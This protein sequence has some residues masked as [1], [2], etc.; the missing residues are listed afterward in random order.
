MLRG[1]GLSV[2][3]VLGLI[4][5]AHAEPQVI[6]DP[7]GAPPEV[8]QSITEAVSAITRLAEDQD[9]REVSRLRRRAWDAARAALQTQGYFSPVVTLDVSEGAPGG[10]EFWDI[11]IEPG[12][13]TQVRQLG[14]NFTGAIQGES[15]SSR[16]E[17]LRE[18][19]LLK[20]GMPFINSEWGS[21]KSDLR[22][23]LSR[24][25]FY[26]ARYT[27]TRATVDP[28]AASADLDLE[29]NSGPPVRLGP[30]R[31]EGLKRVPE[32]LIA[33]YVRYSP[34]DP[35][36]QDQLDMWQQALQSTSFFRGA[37]VT[38]GTADTDNGTGANGDSR[39]GNGNNRNGTRAGVDMSSVEPVEL[40]VH[41]K[42]TEAPARTA[43]GSLGADSDHGVRVE[44]L[45]R[46]NIVWGA[47]VWIET[48]VGLDR[49]RQR[50]FFDVHLPPTLDG[51]HDSVG[52][53]YEHTDIEG[54]ETSRSGIGWT[55]TQKRPGAPGS[56][57]D[58]ETQLGALVTYDKKRIS[59]GERYEVP[60]WSVSWKWLRRDVDKKYD[61]R[62]GNLI[63]FGLGAGTT[64]DDWKP[65]Y[66]TTVRAQR[67]WP[68]GQ[69]DVLTLR[70]EVGKVW[71]DTSRLPQDFS[72]RT[73]G[74]RTVRG[75]RY[76]GIGI[77]SG[78]AIIGAP[79][80]TVASVEYIHYFTDLL[81]ASVFV[82]AGDAAPSFSELDWHLGYGAGL[83]VRTP[84]GPFYVDLA[85]AQKDRRLRLH[86]SL[87]IAF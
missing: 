37:F 83:A 30:L 19:W 79:V 2:C 10:A 75:Y 45:Y 36:D 1:I 84:A 39:G 11:T 5:T 53:L 42:V 76:Q 77:E 40:P 12:E 34:G 22:D 51:Y 6:I 72:F 48:G 61:P 86:F 3:G 70:G 62:E 56:R 47:P 71:S 68:V 26:F 32:S 85:W 69:N 13:R 31:V 44:G 9:L 52:L 74:S 55:R 29:V 27:Y 23:D 15:Y 17:Q 8:L 63:E 81:G 18:Q 87:G 46:Q 41:V 28:Q 24:E 82:D 21:A 43:S 50:A 67:W 60:S 54:E 7:G 4:G 16:R 35:Y 64:L 58:Y 66:R 73:G 38:L 25:E 65:F 33:H 14:L 20:P 59:G 80:L 57:V 49:K 78:D